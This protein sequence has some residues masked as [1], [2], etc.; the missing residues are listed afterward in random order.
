MRRFRIYAPH[1]ER[2]GIK[3]APPQEWN[4]SPIARIRGTFSFTHN[5]VMKKGEK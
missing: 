5:M 3:P 4:P 1:L 2:L